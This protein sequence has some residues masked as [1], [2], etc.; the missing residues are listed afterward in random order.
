MIQCVKVRKNSEV[1]FF[2]R[3]AHEVQ[4]L[5]LHL[6]HIISI[7]WRHFTVFF[8]GSAWEI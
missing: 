5:T 1:N 7:Q 2:Y 6:P 3:A 4:W 8:H